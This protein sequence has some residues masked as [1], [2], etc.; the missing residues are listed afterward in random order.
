MWSPRIR[1]AMVSNMGTSMACPWP[2]RARWYRPAVTALAA[3]M[4][5]MRSTMALGA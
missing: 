5:T 4:P 2:V 1:C 3:L